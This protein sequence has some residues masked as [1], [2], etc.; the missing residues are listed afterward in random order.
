MTSKIKVRPIMIKWWY[1]Q[2]KSL[3]WISA[4]YGVPVSRLYDI[5][6]L[7][8]KIDNKIVLYYLTK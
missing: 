6:E 1:H 3:A 2:D 8:Q 7:Q 4:R 5:L